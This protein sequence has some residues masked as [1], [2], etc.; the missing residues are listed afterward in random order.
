MISRTNVP[1]L[2]CALPKRAYSFVTS[3]TGYYHNSTF[4]IRP[5]APLPSRKKYGNLAK[6]ELND[7][8]E[9]APEDV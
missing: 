1:T 4:E 7:A 5:R 2:T 3:K 6:D 9:P 8:G